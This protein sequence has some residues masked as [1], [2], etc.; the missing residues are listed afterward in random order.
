MISGANYAL[1]E[2]DRRLLLAHA[3]ESGVEIAI[4]PS[5]GTRLI[6]CA[7]KRGPQRDRPV[8]TSSRKTAAP[9]VHRRKFAVSLPIDPPIE[10]SNT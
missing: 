3:L 6:H 4:G 1:E 7:G 10:G 8:H 2:N 5:C 9:Y